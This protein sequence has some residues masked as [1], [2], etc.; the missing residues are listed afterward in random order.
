MAKRWYQHTAVYTLPKGYIYATN[1]DGIY[2]DGD[3]FHN[4]I[5]VLDCVLWVSVT[6]RASH[7]IEH[8]IRIG[9]PSFNNGTVERLGLMFDWLPFQS[10]AKSD[11]LFYNGNPYGMGLNTIAAQLYLSIFPLLVDVVYDVSYIMEVDT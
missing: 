9:V 4:N 3:L 11:K 1:M 5:P 10:G 7:M 2:I 8:W 6:P